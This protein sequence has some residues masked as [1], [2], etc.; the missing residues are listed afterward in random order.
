[1]KRARG[2]V[3][4]LLTMACV[5]VADE[6]AWYEGAWDF[7]Y[8]KS[9]ELNPLVEKARL[10]A[11][12]KKFQRFIVPVKI[13]DAEIQLKLGI[14]LAYRAIEVEEATE[15]WFQVEGALLIRLLKLLKPEVADAEQV[16][17][18]AKPVGENA[19]LV[20]APQIETPIFY[21]IRK[22]VE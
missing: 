6:P 16:R 1:M 7:D 22:S 8:E 5:S 20:E 10:E 12:N 13:T 2:I 17:F 4:M 21:M 19:M 18:Y 14:K 9:V 3:L 11:I 15:E